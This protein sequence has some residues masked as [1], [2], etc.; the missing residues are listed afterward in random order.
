MITLR[1][2]LSAAHCAETDRGRVTWVRLGDF[3]Y[4]ISEDSAHVDKRIVEIIIH[5]K[6]SS[7]KSHHDIA[8]FKID[9]KIE[10]PYVFPVCLQTEKQ[11]TEKRANMTGWGRTGT[12][13]DLRV[14][15]L[16][17]DM[18]IYN[19]TEC[20]RLRFSGDNPKTPLGHQPDF[21]FC[22]GIPDGSNR[23]VACSGH[24]GSPLVIKKPDDCVQ[25][26]VGVV[27]YG[28]ACSIPNAPG[29]YTRVS[30]YISWIEET[31]LQKDMK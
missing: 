21:M 3:A 28:A 29:E 8:L 22:A 25:I 16:E 19:D 23:T 24:S 18:E 9:R 12:D 13:N 15:I 1:H 2:I 20:K 17:T 30:N 5:P 31:L 26:L 10:S 7:S 6:Y 11:I 27:S 4:K 14:Q